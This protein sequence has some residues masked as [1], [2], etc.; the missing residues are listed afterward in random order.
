M[1]K[2][3]Q[4]FFISLLVSVI[5]IFT[6]AYGEVELS[7]KFKEEL[8]YLQ[9]EMVQRIM[10]EGATKTTIP[11]RKTPGSVTVITRENIKKSTARSTIE[12]LRLV[13]G[14][15]V[16]WNIMMQTVDIRGFGQNAFTNRV[17]LLIDGLP[18]NSW[19]K[20]GFPQQPGL[21]FFPLQNIKQIEVIHGP[22]SS[23]YGEN[24]YWG[25]INIVSLSGE[26]IDGLW[27]ELYA[28]DRKTRSLGVMAGKKFGSESSILISGRYLQTQYPMKLWMDSGSVV[29]QKD[30]FLKGKF[31]DFQISY[32]YYNDRADG[33]SQPLRLRLPVFDPTSASVVRT[34]DVTVNYQS[35]S[36]VRQTIGIAALKY[37]HMADDDSWSF[38]SD[39]SHARRNGMHCAACHGKDQPNREDFKK[40]ADH[41]YQL[42]GD[43]RLG[44]HSVP[45]ND[46]LFGIEAKQV[47][48]ADHS[49][50]LST[51]ADTA[52]TDDHIVSNYRKAG[53]YFQDQLSLLNDDL[54]IF[55]GI[56][57][58]MP[59]NRDLFDERWSPSFNLVANASK[60]LI[61]RGG[62]SKAFHFPDFSQLYQNSW[63]LQKEADPTGNPAVGFGFLNTS[64]INID[65]I[66]NK[67]LNPEKI[68]MFE[69][70]LEYFHSPRLTTKL[71]FFHSEVEDFI[72]PVFDYEGINPS[73]E[74]N[75]TYQ[76]VNHPDNAFIVGSELEFNWQFSK[77]VSGLVNYSYQNQ[78]QEGNKVDSDGK[79]FEF[80]YAPHNKVNVATYLGPFKGFTG[81]VEIIWRD[82]YDIPR[83]W[84]FLN[85]VELLDRCTGQT[86]PCA[87]G[88]RMLDF[89]GYTY[90]NAK[91]GYDLPFG[92][93]TNGRK[94]FQISIHGKN[95]L[96][97]RP[98]ETV[99]GVDTQ[100]AGREFF[101]QLEYTP[102]R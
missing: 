95:L 44:I 54:N 52:T 12:L 57:Y 27:S 83:E 63:F 32:Y 69:F 84:A 71:S 18:Y 90:L 75:R 66:P 9:A 6:S 36:K 14:V 102:K 70:S 13:A 46:L 74:I 94:P 2:R 97:E 48:T 31:N 98:E 42:Y 88:E 7:S 5:S 82:S 4:F 26:D 3:N 1:K 15:N 37:K 78:Y 61:I 47:E 101:I 29:Q 24:A 33:Y 100:V 34:E 73:L 41:G 65:F 30:I 56:R 50:E 19:N 16:R 85:D 39:I 93:L 43:F 59:T 55:S 49:I 8:K 67:E 77:R 25:V 58:D 28:G 72:V 64:T 22:G 38:S 62:W 92:E 40:R 51:T 80:V 79:A 10:V 99:M 20:G 91:L 68:S 35:V 60:N 21:D 76:Y 87:D 53:F 86:K 23:L 81:A 45:A 11:L 96:D 17:L 89:D